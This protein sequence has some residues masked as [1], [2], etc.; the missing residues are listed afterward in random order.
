MARR[1]NLPF[2]FALAQSFWFLWAHALKGQSNALLNAG[3]ESWSNGVPQQWSVSGKSYLAQDTGTRSEGGS[4]IRF[5]IPSTSTTVEVFQDVPVIGGGIY[6]FSCDVFDNTAQG[7]LG[8]LV[9]WR[10][11][12]GSLTTVSSGRSSD[13]SAWQVLSIL[14]QTAPAEATSGRVRI[15]GYQQSGSGGGS[16]YADAAVFSGDS[17]LPVRLNRLEAEPSESGVEILWS[18]ESELGVLGYVISRSESEQGPYVSVVTAMIEARGGGSGR[19]EYRYLDAEAQAGIDLWYRLESLEA[20]GTINLLDTVRFE[21]PKSCFASGGVLP[22]IEAHPNPFNPV[23]SIGIR[24]PADAA[25]TRIRILVYDMSGRITRT[26][27]QGIVNAGEALFPWDGTD[28][29]GAVLPSG[30]YLCRVESADAPFETLRM[31]KVK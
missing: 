31:T 18:T 17:P 28:D 13:G 25:G 20:D 23:T 8:L 21:T 6:S 19:C 7:E 2:L 10:N 5:Q 11:A 9:N 29:N 14:N 12:G 3:F 24:F 26:L 30:I 16:V 22:R 1:R 4:S 15:R 27:F